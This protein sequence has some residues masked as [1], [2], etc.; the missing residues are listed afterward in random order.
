LFSDLT[1]WS[2]IE[3]NGFPDYRYNDKE[4]IR[5]FADESAHTYEWLVAHGVIFVRKAPDT[6]AEMPAA[7]LLPGSITEGPMKDVP[8]FQLMGE[9]A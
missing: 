5:A 4:V 1:D 7:I 9:R 6:W 2:V 8:T 3:R